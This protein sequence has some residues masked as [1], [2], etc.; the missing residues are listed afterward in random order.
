MGFCCLLENILCYNQSMKKILSFLVA[1][2]MT[3]GVVTSSGIMSQGAFADTCTAPTFLGFKTWYD[4]LPMSG[5]CKTVLSPSG[6][7]ELVSFVWT[8]VLNVIYDLSEAIGIVTVGFIIY[9]GYLFITSEGDATKSAKAKKTLTGAII[10]LLVAVFATIIIN[11]IR[12]ILG[13]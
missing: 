12:T 3:A 2:L 13:F 6:N 9:G 11:T 7:N 4:G 1:V 10:G 8:I 5:D